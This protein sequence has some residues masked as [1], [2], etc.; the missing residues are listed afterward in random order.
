MLDFHDQ[1]LHC[2]KGYFPPQ[3][4]VIAHRGCSRV[5]AKPH[6]PLPYL[7]PSRWEAVPPT[8][9]PCHHLVLLFLPLGGEIILPLML[10]GRGFHHCFLP[11]LPF[12]DATFE[13]QRTNYS[14]TLV[15]QVY[16]P[17]YRKQ[18]TNKQKT[19]VFITQKYV[20]NTML[21][22]SKTH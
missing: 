5:Q 8:L 20:N 22:K 1:I 13:K 7:S 12:S 2:H 4:C 11:C 3:V 16:L 18:R 15:A 10:D 21:V 6:L 9:P 14:L 17:N 19:F